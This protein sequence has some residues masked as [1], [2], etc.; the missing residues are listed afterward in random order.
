MGGGADNFWILM[1]STQP[2][3]SNNI[4]FTNVDLFAFYIGI[5]ATPQHQHIHQ[6][7]QPDPNVSQHPSEPPQLISFD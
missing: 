2:R 5:T 1:P 6:S 7:N 3:F 4:I